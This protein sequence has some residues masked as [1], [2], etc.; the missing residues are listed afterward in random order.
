[1]TRHLI[2]SP[3]LLSLPAWNSLPAGWCLLHSFPAWH[4]VAIFLLSPLWNQ[5]FRLHMWN[6]VSLSSPVWFGII[7]SSCVHIVTNDR[8]PFFPR[9]N[10]VLLCV[11]HTVF[12][13]SSAKGRLPCFRCLTSLSWD[14]HY[15]WPLYISISSWL[16]KHLVVERVNQM[17][18]LF[19]MLE[20]PS[21]SLSI[22]ATLI[23]DTMVC[24][25]MVPLFHACP[26]LVTF[27]FLLAIF[28]MRWYL[29]VLVLICL[30]WTICLVEYFFLVMLGWFYVPVGYINIFF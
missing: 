29:T 30:P 2:Y 19:A 24:S 18:D 17:V 13:P 23:Y 27:S 15:R 11:H 14:R 6:H 4:L 10:K 21:M 5:P 12:I 3:T 20:G 28:L 25:G 7:I 16:D 26:A 22:V 9:L 1:M 8:V